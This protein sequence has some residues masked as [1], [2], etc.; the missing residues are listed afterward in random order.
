MDHILAIPKQI[1]VT[2]LKALIERKYSLKYERFEPGRI[3][4]AVLRKR[5][6]FWSYD[7]ITEE[8]KADMEAVSW[9]IHI[10]KA[11]QVLANEQ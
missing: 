9:P 5:P 4:Y 10:I 1:C 3:Y 11:Y 6:L 2:D 7:V 8:E